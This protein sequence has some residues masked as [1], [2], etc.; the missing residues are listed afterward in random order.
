VYYKTTERVRCNV[1]QAV[2]ILQHDERQNEY[3][4]MHRKRRVYYRTMKDRM[5]AL[6]CTESGAYYRNDN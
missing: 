2:H 1:Q 4:T 5:S 3:V 6:Q